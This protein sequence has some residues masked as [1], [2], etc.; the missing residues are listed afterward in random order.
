VVALA[1]TM[2]ADKA[3]NSIIHL[4]EQWL[5][6]CRLTQVV[7]NQKGTFGLQVGRIFLFWATR[8]LHCLSSHMRR[9]I[10]DI[11]EEW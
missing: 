4:K 7:S 9:S 2:A 3:M 1:A 11:S 10:A 6:Q 8:F 5:G